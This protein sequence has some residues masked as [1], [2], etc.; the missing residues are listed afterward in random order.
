M[1]KS[2][3]R[4]KIKLIKQANGGRVAHATEQMPHSVESICCNKSASANRQFNRKTGA[5][6]GDILMANEAVVI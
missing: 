1:L 5:A 4:L 3:R 6:C 2:R